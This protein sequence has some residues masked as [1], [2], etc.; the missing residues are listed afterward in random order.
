M[1]DPTATWKSNLPPGKNFHFSR[2]SKTK[3][4]DC[5]NNNNS[6]K[7]AAPQANGSKKGIPRFQ[8][9]L[10]R[11]RNEKNSQAVAMDL[12]TLQ[13]LVQKKWNSSIR[14]SP[15]TSNSLSPAANETDLEMAVNTENL[16]SSMNENNQNG[17]DAETNKT[18]HIL[19]PPRVIT[20]VRKCTNEIVRKEPVADAT[21]ESNAK[22]AESK[23]ARK[24]TS[25]LPQTNKE[26][27]K[28]GGPTP[29]VLS[30]TFDATGTKNDSPSSDKAAMEHGT[31]PDHSSGEAIPIPSVENPPRESSIAKESRKHP[32]QTKKDK[33]SCGGKLHSHQ[34]P[35]RELSGN[36]LTIDAGVDLASPS[37]SLLTKVNLLAHS[38]EKSTATKEASSGELLVGRDKEEEEE[39]DVPKTSLWRSETEATT[40]VMG[41][42]PVAKFRRRLIAV[43][44]DLQSDNGDENPSTMDAYITKPNQDLLVSR[45]DNLACDNKNN[46]CQSLGYPLSFVDNENDCELFQL[47]SQSNHFRSSKAF[48]QCLGCPSSFGD[49]ESDCD[50]DCDSHVRSSEYNRRGHSSPKPTRLLSKFNNVAP[51]KVPRTNPCTSGNRYPTL[52]ESTIDSDT[53]AVPIYINS[54]TREKGNK[55]ETDFRIANH[56]LR[57]STAA[58]DEI[59]ASALASQKKQAKSKGKRKKSAKRNSKELVRTVSGKGSVIASSNREK[60][61]FARRNRSSVGQP[62][63]KRT[64]TIRNSQDFQE[65]VRKNTRRVSLESPPKTNHRPPIRHQVPSSETVGFNDEDSSNWSADWDND[66]DSSDWSADW[67][68]LSIESIPRTGFYSSRDDGD[69]DESSLND[70]DESSLNGVTV[71]LGDCPT[72]EKENRRANSKQSLQKGQSEIEFSKR[73]KSGK[74]FEHLRQSTTV[75]CLESGSRGTAL[76]IHPNSSRVVSNCHSRCGGFYYGAKKVFIIC[77]HPSIRLVLFLFYIYAVLWVGYSPSNPIILRNAGTNSSRINLGSFEKH[78]RMLHHI[79]FSKNPNLSLLQ[80]SKIHETAMM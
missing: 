28:E 7:D 21:K 12:E 77:H 9:R 38:R 11:S 40:R 27:T 75:S 36:E 62:L 14:T 8:K 50:H 56:P 23:E 48:N 65:L 55:P 46:I 61:A 30:R 74:A 16:E 4:A 18:S 52:D 34:E 29:L 60:S 76:G 45:S 32:N 72:D 35:S 49:D 22:T 47:A 20:T 6:N 78:K 43:S 53:N 1:E 58:L 17:D 5:D 41:L 54:K 69:N 2:R 42:S 15:S 79:R 66:E 71:F 64:K 25:E 13:R 68:N 10:S 33:G 63:R 24:K 57:H 31:N 59:I 80:S 70:N 39:A 3:T 26:E 44:K 73:R 67:D 19:G 51:T 37:P